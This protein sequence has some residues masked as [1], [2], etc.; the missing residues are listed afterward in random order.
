[1]NPSQL[2]AMETA[3]ALLSEHFERVL[4]VVDYEKVGQDGRLEDHREGF[5]HGGLMAALGLS[6]YAKARILESGERYFGPTTHTGGPETEPPK[7][8]K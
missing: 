7:G 4:I 3:Y 8:E 5:W 1:M 2:N 6:E